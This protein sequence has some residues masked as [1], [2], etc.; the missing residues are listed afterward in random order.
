M[1]ETPRSTGGW[2]KRKWRDRAPWMALTSRGRTLLHTRR[3]QRVRV[4]NERIQALFRMQS[5]INRGLNQALDSIR[6]MQKQHNLPAADHTNL[7]EYGRRLSALHARL[8]FADI[9]LNNFNN[10]FAALQAEME[11]AKETV[12]QPS[13]LRKRV[14]PLAELDKEA[15]RLLRGYAHLEDGKTRDALT[16]A[17]DYV[18]RL[19]FIALGSPQQVQAQIALLE[20][21]GRPA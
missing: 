9:S 5:E 8:A 21:M 16:A 3:L 7:A 20:R 10:R 15:K 18:A 6:R 17:A 13:A 2:L 11:K 1:P 19:N 14:D 12:A 4:A